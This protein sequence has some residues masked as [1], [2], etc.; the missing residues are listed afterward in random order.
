M[1]ARRELS[2]ESLYVYFNEESEVLFIYLY[3]HLFVSFVYGLFKAAVVSS[4][5]FSVEL[6]GEL[7]GNRVYGNDHGL[8]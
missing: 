4:R 6:W 8:I 7:I 5:Y 1:T 2:K 3:I